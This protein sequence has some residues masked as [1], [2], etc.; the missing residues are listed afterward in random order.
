M[1]GQDAQKHAVTD[2]TNKASI[3]GY[4]PMTGERNKAA[5]GRH[6]KIA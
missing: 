6:I 5:R 1:S 4:P 2:P 3:H